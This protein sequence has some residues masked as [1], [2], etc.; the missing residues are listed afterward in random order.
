MATY[1]RQDQAKVTVTLTK[2]NGTAVDLGIFNKKGETGSEADNTMYAPGGL[3]TEIPLGGRRTKKT[4]SV[5]RGLQDTD[6][7]KTIDTQVGKGKLTIV[8]LLLDDDQNQ[9]GTTETITGV[10]IE[11]TKSEV[12]STGNDPRTIALVIAPD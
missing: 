12:D 6:D 11:A 5:E 4:V 10:L 2:A 1:L 8:E 3:A 9:I 7:W